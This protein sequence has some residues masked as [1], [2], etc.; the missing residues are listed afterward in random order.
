[1]KGSSTNDGSTGSNGGPGPLKL[2]IAGTSLNWVPPE[3]EG[4]ISPTFV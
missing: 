1:M 4:V 2:T 3:W